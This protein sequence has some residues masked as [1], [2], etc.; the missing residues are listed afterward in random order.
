M[1][2]STYSRFHNSVAGTVSLL[3]C[4]HRSNVMFLRE[5]IFDREENS[6]C[7]ATHKTILCNSLA[8]IFLMLQI[9]FEILDLKLALQVTLF[10]VKSTIDNLHMNHPNFAYYMPRDGICLMSIALYM[11][12]SNGFLRTV[13]KLLTA[14]FVGHAIVNVYLTTITNVYYVLGYYKDL[15][16]PHV[17]SNAPVSVSG[18]FQYHYIPST[19][20]MPQPGLYRH[21]PPPPVPQNLLHQ[22]DARNS[23]SLHHYAGS[24]YRHWNRATFDDYYY[25]GEDEDDNDEDDDDGSSLES[26]ET[27]YTVD[28]DNEDNWVFVMEELRSTAKVY[29]V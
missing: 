10:N 22:T 24:S 19:R 16:P 8:G 4:K 15:T 3:R 28:L 18:Q 20:P 1:Q 12:Y 17:Y 9:V 21:R 13:L 27:H 5:M 26:S 23:S 11:V 14:T 6:Q 2:S 25:E 29:C 7:S